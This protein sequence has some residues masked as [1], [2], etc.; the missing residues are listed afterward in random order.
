MTKFLK[1]H[2]FSSWQKFVQHINTV[3]MKTS[4]KISY[5]IFTSLFA[6]VMIGSSIPDVISHPI[7]IEG[8]KKMGY[9]AYL[10]PF[11]GIAKLLG[12]FVILLPGFPRVKE[13][14]YAGLM[15]DLVGATYSIIASGQPISAWSFMALPLFLGIGS[16]VSY[17]QREKAR[18]VIDKEEVKR[19]R[20]NSSRRE[21]DPALG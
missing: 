17:C 20:E 21:M 14:A 12:V 10:V 11:I 13:W 15:I 16:Y 5:W 1:E 2:S 19:H 8:F 4:T 3:K 7:A 6:F 18:L 9:P